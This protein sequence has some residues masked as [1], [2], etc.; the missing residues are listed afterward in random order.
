[1]PFASLQP[2]GGLVPVVMGTV[3]MGM[4]FVVGV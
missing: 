2:D 1:M 3:V 4:S